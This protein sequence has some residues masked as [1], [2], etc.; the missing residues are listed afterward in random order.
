[1]AFEPRGDWKAVVEYP[2]DRLIALE[3]TVADTEVAA[4]APVDYADITGTPT[5]PDAAPAGT[6]AQLDAGTDTTPR[7]FSAKDINEF[8]AA[9]IAAII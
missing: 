5:I 1:M 4:N 6:R 8:V 9:E 7:L 2:A 3:R